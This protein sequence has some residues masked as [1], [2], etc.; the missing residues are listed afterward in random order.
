M[1]LSNKIF[2]LKLLQCNVVGNRT[3]LKIKV[4][5]AKTTD[6]DRLI[7][8]EPKGKSLI[9]YVD[10][11]HDFLALNFDY[12][13]AKSSDLELKLRSLVQRKLEYRPLIYK[14]LPFNK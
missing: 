14:V 5:T 3:I 9:F 2:P 12:S 13:L 7:A 1:N 11:I 4:R 8:I 10:N 6:D